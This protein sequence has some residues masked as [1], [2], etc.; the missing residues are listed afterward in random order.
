[1]P[2]TTVKLLLEFE[3]GVG[4][5]RMGRK[6]MAG[7]NN[8]PQRFKQSMSEGLAVQSQINIKLFLDATEAVS[9]DFFN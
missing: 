8:G 5:R 6:S 4:L 9:E 1:M 2:A 3:H 7:E